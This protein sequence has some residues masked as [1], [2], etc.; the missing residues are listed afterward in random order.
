MS[1]QKSKQK[2]DVSH[3]R[4]TCYRNNG[5]HS[6]YGKPVDFLKSI[7]ELMGLDCNYKSNYLG[8]ENHN[9]GK[10]TQFCRLEKDK[11]YVEVL[12]KVKGKWTGYVIWCYFDYCK[13]F[14][15]F[16]TNTAYSIFIHHH[17]FLPT[18]DYRHYI[19]IQDHYQ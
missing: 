19:P 15:V 14:L 17:L 5:H 3:P 2:T 10:T 11:W 16:I 8:I 7:D 12:L 9:T 18:Y 13:K 4:C 1:F 6:V